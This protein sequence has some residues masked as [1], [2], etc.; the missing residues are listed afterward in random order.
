MSLKNNLRVIVAMGAAGFVVLAALW[1]TT[2]R[3]RILRAKQDNARN[4]VETAWSIAAQYH[5]LE[6]DGK[7][8]PEEAQKRASEVIGMMRYDNDNYLWINDLHPTMVMHPTKPQLNGTDLTNFKDPAGKALFVEMVDTVRKNGAGFVY[9]MWPKPGSDQPVSKLSYV[10]GFEPWGWLIGTGIYMDD[11]DAMWRQSALQAAGLTLT[12]LIALAVVAFI[13]WQRLFGRLRELSERLKDVAEGDGDLTKR[14]QVEAQDEVGEL[15]SCFNTFLDKLQKALWQVADNTESLAI[16]SEQIS[17]TSREQ[18]QGAETQ[19]SQTLQVA[20]AMQEMAATVQQV[21]ENSGHAADTSQ[22]A[23]EVARQG[24]EIV[25][26]TLARMHAIAESVEQTSKKVHNLG[27]RSEEIGQIIFVISDIAD[28]TNLL[29]L[30]AAIEAARAGEQGR[31][32]AVV[33]DE[34]RKLAERTAEATHRIT[35]MIHTIQSETKDAVAAM[36]QNNV[37]VEKG[38]KSTV[39][40]GDSLGVIIEMSENVG[41]MVTNIATAAAE[42]SATTESINS[43][44]DQIAKITAA[45]A[46]GAQQTSKALEDL[47]GLALN[48]QQLVGQFRLESNGH[49]RR[50]GN[51]RPEPIHQ[52]E[53]RQSRVQATPVLTRTP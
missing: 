11:V 42:Q 47:S 22:K 39:L 18:A 17:R 7:L 28:Q 40:A 15:G 34:V 30:N 44:V 9:Y 16:A 6:Q 35:G 14:I 29:A 52:K 45:H 5:T 37:E 21:S 12:C 23:A 36:Q 19:G 2:E 8:R 20:S 33:A 53:V 13:V 51:G 48:L 43:N 38:V 50:G 4:L 32:F 41:S 25:K 26:E 1:L 46:A 24:G 31:G 27:E 49:G 3:S 10:K